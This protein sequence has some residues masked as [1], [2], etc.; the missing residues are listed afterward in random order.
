MKISRTFFTAFILILIAIT[1]FAVSLLVIKNSHQAE[2]EGMLRL[3]CYGV[4]L[5]DT[6]NYEKAQKIIDTGTYLIKGNKVLRKAYEM[7]LKYQH[8]SNDNS[9]VRVNVDMSLVSPQYLIDFE[10]K[11]YYVYDTD[12]AVIHEKPI[13]ELVSDILYLPRIRNMTQTKL[14][15]IDTTVYVREQTLYTGTAI[16]IETKDTVVFKCSRKPLPLRSPLNDWIPGVRYDIIAI[17]ISMKSR[18]NISE[19]NWFMIEILD[20]KAEKVNPKE[21]IIDVNQITRKDSELSIYKQ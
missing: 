16:M 1:G 2:E 17:G 9:R 20:L 12:S 5:K 21:F 7:E 10:K 8:A 18:V 19:K 6:F 4:S 11:L 13:R 3:R 14:L 15:Q